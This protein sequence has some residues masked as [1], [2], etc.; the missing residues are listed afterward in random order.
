MGKE[1]SRDVTVQSVITP[2]GPQL[3]FDDMEALLKWT[4]EGDG[5]DFAITKA[6]TLVYTG[7][8]ALSIRTRATNPAIGDYAS[9]YRTFPPRFKGRMS[10]MG[11][12]ATLVLPDTDILQLDIRYDNCVELL[13]A[14]FQLDITNSRIKYLNSAGG[15]TEVT[16]TPFLTYNNYWNFF[17]L[18]VSFAQKKYST[19]TINDDTFDLSD[20]NMQVEATT[21]CYTG[22]IDF[23]V[24]AATNQ[25]PTMVVDNVLLSG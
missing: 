3:L 8:Y 15:Y 17:N 2:F 16:A 20:I 7:S 22:R 14:G 13:H 12:M 21:S 6:Q 19:L 9:A 11:H 10:I 25:R 1:Y 23:L 5:A 4:G 18:I 24:V